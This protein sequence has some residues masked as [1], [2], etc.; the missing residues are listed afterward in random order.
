MLDE[1]KR[2]KFVPGKIAESS[3]RSEECFDVKCLQNFHFTLLALGLVLIQYFP[4]TDSFFPFGVVMCILYQCIYIRSKSYAFL[5]WFY[6]GLELK[7]LLWVS[8][9]LN[10]GLL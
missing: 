1:H 4:N 3:W 6:K 8:Q 7:D 9:M 10:L 2:E 5:F